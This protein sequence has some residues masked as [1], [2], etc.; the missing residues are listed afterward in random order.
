MHPLVLIPPAVFSF[1]LGAAFSSSRKGLSMLP[2]EKKSPLPGVPALAW[3]KFVTTMIVLPKSSVTPRGRLGYFGMDARRL[4]DVGFMRDAHKESVCGESGVWVGDWVTPLTRDKFLANSPA[5]YEAFTRSMRG[6]A[7]KVR[8][9]VG[10]D[11]DGKRA[12]LSGLLAVGHLAG[13]A[14][15][16]SWVKDPKV[17]QKFTSTTANFHRSN[18]IF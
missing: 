5:Q 4:A 12:T 1:L 16:A 17:R 15:V 9:L 18:D 14:G 2:P 10:S 8:G 6:L 11:V 7:P 13:D 3:E